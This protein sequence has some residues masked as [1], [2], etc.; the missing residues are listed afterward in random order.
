[1]SPLPCSDLLRRKKFRPRLLWILCGVFAATMVWDTPQRVLFAQANP[2]P[3]PMV[4]TFR[5]RLDDKE[6]KPVNGVVSM[7]FSIYAVPSGGSMLWTDN[8]QVAVLDGIFSV[9]L[10]VGN[11][12][13]TSLLTQGALYVG[14]AVEQDVEM[15]P[16]TQFQ[17]VPYAWV[18][19]QVVGAITPR[20]VSIRGWG[21]VIDNQGRWSGKFTQTSQGTP[22]AAGERGPAGPAGPTG[23]TGPAGP[24]GDKG[25]DGSGPKGVTGPQGP[26][27]DRGPIGSQGPQ[28]PQGSQGPQGPQG[29]QGP[30]GPPPY[31]TYT[32][33]NSSSSIN[34]SGSLTC[35]SNGILVSGSC[36][37]TLSLSSRTA[38]CRCNTGVSSCY[39]TITCCQ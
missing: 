30:Q 1:M 33:Q 22:G 3:I 39:L 32:C 9:M 17:A 26:E 38:S 19:Q 16:R 21:R 10:G 8:K 18:A 27:G 12:L 13:P 2:A 7:K 15:F 20:S 31:R 24:Q 4:L 11:P 23:P 29:S 25:L 6:G 28:G 36:G 5:A 14:V 34:S 37:G 35:P